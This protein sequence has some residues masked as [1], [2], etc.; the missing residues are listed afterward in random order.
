EATQDS[1]HRQARKEGQ[2]DHQVQD[3]HHI[4]G[5]LALFPG[6]AVGQHLRDGFSRKDVLQHREIHVMTQ[7]VIF[8]KVTYAKGHQE[9]PFIWHPR[10]R[11]TLVCHIW[12]S[13]SYLNGIDRKGSPLLYTMRLQEPLLDERPGVVE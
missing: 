6:M 3:G 10:V 9:A 11:L 7:L 2:S 1:S 13:S 4:Q 8:R 5:P 12:T